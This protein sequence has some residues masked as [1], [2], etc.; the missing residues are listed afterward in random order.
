MARSS[1]SAPRWASAH[2]SCTAAGLSR[3]LS[4]LLRSMRL[5]GPGRFVE[6]RWRWAS[7][8]GECQIV[9][10]LLAHIGEAVIFLRRGNLKRPKLLARALHLSSVAPA[11]LTY[12]LSLCEPHE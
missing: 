3:W 1:A 6:F 2:K 11:V 8:V 12:I 9:V 5:S 7:C 4:L 10:V